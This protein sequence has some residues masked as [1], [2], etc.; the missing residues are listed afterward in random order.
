MQSKLGD[1]EKDVTAIVRT[2][3][4]KSCVTYTSV[5]DKDSHKL[6]LTI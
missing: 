5:Y 6:D 2:R 1:Q 4:Q 3:G